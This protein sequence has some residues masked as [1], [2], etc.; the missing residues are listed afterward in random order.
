M[1]SVASDADFSDADSRLCDGPRQREDGSEMGTGR[2]WTF[3]DGS[4]SEDDLE[5]VKVHALHHTMDPAPG[6]WRCARIVTPKGATRET[7][8]VSQWA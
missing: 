5:A 2:I 6:N 1:L 4:R 8:A 7:R 3:D